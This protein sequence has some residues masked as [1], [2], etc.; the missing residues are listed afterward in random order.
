[1]GKH[2]INIELTAI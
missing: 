1:L 2:S